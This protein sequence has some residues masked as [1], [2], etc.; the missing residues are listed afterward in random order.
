MFDRIYYKGI[1]K[2]LANSLM[3]VIA[4]MSFIILLLSGA[5][6]H[7]SHYTEELDMLFYVQKITHHYLNILWLKL[8][9][10]VGIA[11]FLSLI[12]LII[13]IASL[14][15]QVGEK[16]FYIYALT[17]RE[18]I[19]RSPSRS[20]CFDYSAAHYGKFL[21]TQLLVGIKIFLWALLFIIPGIYKAYEYRLI[22]YIVATNPDISLTD[23]TSLSAR[24]MDGR[25]FDLFVMDLS[26]IGWKLLDALTAGLLGGF[27]LRGYMEGSYAA[28]YVSLNIDTVNI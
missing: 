19:D 5:F 3:K 10:P 1:G 16:A 25:K 24:Y 17:Y 26:F 21:A 4:P 22:P 9:I 28:F 13:K 6:I 2:N 27:W 14:P 18:G 12:F 8:E 11:L 20:L 7:T 23:A 15:L